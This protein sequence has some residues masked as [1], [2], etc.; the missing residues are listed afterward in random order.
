MI[1]KGTEGEKRFSYI[2]TKRGETAAPY[3]KLHVYLLNGV[4]PYSE[5]RALGPWFVGNWVEENNSFLFFSKP[6]KDRVMAI[7][8][9]RP[10]LEVL[11]EFAFD[12]DQWQGESLESIKIAGFLIRPYWYREGKWKGP[13]EIQEILLDPGV[14]FGNGL[15]PTT[16]DCL[17]AL[18][19]L[20]R[21]RHIT[22]VL[23]LGTGT[24]ILAIASALMGAKEVLAVDINP[25]CVKTA[26]KNV[27]L[28]GVEDIVRVIEG[29]AYDFSG[30]GA[31]L[32]VANLDY[33]V[34]SELLK[35]QKFINKRWYIFSGLMRTPYR[36]LKVM[37]EK[38]GM[39]VEK[40]WDHEM[41]WFTIAC[42]GR[43]KA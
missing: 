11:E 12:Y 23:D 2:N 22:N 8:E 32:I 10:G 43:C 26:E 34:I 17:R 21:S 4:L 16:Q 29:S 9:R 39:R 5:E 6:S 28:N 15:H 13:S 14:V 42:K 20:M 19:W 38:C 1:S 36:K 33:D 25:L 35:E 37:V 30:V 3:D 7:V 40:E 41:T 31:D 24:G 27:R 18:R